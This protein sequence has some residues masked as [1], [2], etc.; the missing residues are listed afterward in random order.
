MDL[1]KDF[2][3]K[4]MFQSRNLEHVKTISTMKFPSFFHAERSKYSFSPYLNKNVHSDA[5][6]ANRENL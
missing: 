3:L 4:K 2:S 5:S 6:N 1:L